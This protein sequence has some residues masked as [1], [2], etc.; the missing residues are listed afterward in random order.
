[1]KA[2]KNN[3]WHTVL[4]CC[5]NWYSKTTMFQYSERIRRSSDIE[6]MKKHAPSS[7]YVAHKLTFSKVVRAGL[8]IIFGTWVPS[9]MICHRRFCGITACSGPSYI[10]IYH[11][12]KT[13]DEL[14]DHETT[15]Q[16]R[17]YCLKL[18]TLA[19][20]WRKIPTRLRVVCATRLA[21]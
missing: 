7:H 12:L 16:T 9:W 11:N 14:F 5:L 10:S 19:D 4:V 6:C 3:L 1:M 15:Q 8:T 18:V 2:K 17:A 21:L 20:R 13:K